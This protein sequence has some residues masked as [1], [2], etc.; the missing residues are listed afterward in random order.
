M[1]TEVIMR[2]DSREG[3]T[4]PSAKEETIAKHYAKQIPSVIYFFVAM[5]T[6]LDAVAEMVKYDEAMKE[7][8]ANTTPGNTW[9]TEED[10]A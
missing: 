1:F 7:Y 3:L 6:D 9:I 8:E 5:T 4:R 10:D 2:Y